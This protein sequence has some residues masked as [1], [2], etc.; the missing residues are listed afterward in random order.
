M[1]NRKRN[2][3]KAI[4]LDNGIR[5]KEGQVR[6]NLANMKTLKILKEISPRT[7]KFRAEN[8]FNYVLNS[9]LRPINKLDEKLPDIGLEV[10]GDTPAL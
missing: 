1:R 6:K 7:K 2:R 3:L 10:Y 4:L 8:R 9:M 5:A